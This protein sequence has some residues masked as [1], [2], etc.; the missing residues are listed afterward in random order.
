[1]GLACGGSAA[2]TETLTLG[3]RRPQIGPLENRRG[4]MRTWLIA[5]AAVLAACTTTAS[6]PHIDTAAVPAFSHP[7]LSADS[8]LAH[9][10]VLASDEFEGRARSCRKCR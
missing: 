6:A 5:A 4:Q 7:S 10:N 1:M 3:R 8:L 2:A 9:V